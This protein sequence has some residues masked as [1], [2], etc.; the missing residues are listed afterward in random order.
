MQHMDSDVYAFIVASLFLTFNTSAT[1]W[2]TGCSGFVT[3]LFRAAVFTTIIEACKWDVMCV[4]GTFENQIML[5]C[6]MIVMKK[7]EVSTSTAL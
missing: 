6:D 3:T 1:V 7:T 2:S 4:I 5:L